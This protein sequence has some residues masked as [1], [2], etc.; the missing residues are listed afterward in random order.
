M[1]MMEANFIHTT[2][3]SYKNKQFEGLKILLDDF[4]VHP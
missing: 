1:V 4:W 2:T 3:I